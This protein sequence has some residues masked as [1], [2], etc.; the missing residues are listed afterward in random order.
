MMPWQA[1]QYNLHFTTQVCKSSH[2]VD[3]GTSG[4]SALSPRAHQ[5]KLE[6]GIKSLSRFETLF[7]IL[8]LVI[9][10]DLDHANIKT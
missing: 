9:Q 7:M 8:V 10:C 5:D 1:T 4:W 2:Q 6:R 3:K